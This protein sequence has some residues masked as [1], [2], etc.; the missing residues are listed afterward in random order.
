MPDLT[1]C[2][3]TCITQ[4]G[5]SDLAGYELYERADPPLNYCKCLVKKGV[6]TSRTKGVGGCPLEATICSTLYIEAGPIATALQKPLDGY[7]CYKNNFYGCGREGSYCCPG[8]KCFTESDL[9]L[10]CRVTHNLGFDKELFQNTKHHR[11]DTEAAGYGVFSDI[12]AATWADG[13]PIDI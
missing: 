9:N 4:F 5:Y 12:C 11:Y 7:S 8:A 2:E 1:I 13:T 6:I 3:E 10:K